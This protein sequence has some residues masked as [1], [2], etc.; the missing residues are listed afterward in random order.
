VTGRLR[1][2]TVSGVSLNLDGYQLRAGDAKAEL[3]TT[4]FALLHVLMDNAGRVLATQQIMD[5]VWG[6]GRHVHPRILNE[7]IRRVRRRLQQV[8]AL[9][10]LVRTVRGTG[11]VFDVIDQHGM[12]SGRGHAARYL[13]VPG[14]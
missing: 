1:L 6:P 5:Q 10:N 13:D 3:N 14:P 11:Y 7:N 9:G 12:P 2:L 8:G 4:E